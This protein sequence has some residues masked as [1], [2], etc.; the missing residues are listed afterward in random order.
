VNFFSRDEST[1]LPVSSP[2]LPSAAQPVGSPAPAA[3]GQEVFKREVWPL[4][5]LGGFLLLLVEW[6][7]A[8]RIAIRRALTEWQTRRGV[9]RET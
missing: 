5:A 1:A 4:V 6:T 9:R 7:Y 3:A 2:D 8:Q